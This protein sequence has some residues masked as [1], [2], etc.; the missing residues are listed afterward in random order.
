MLDIHVIRT[1]TERVKAAVARKKFAVDIDE[2][3]SVDEARR[4]LAG[5]ID[6]LRAQRNEV[7]ASIPKL[8]GQAKQDAISQGRE[9]RA[10]IGTLE[11]QQRTTDVRFDDLMMHFLL[12][13]FNQAS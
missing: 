6:A 13:T 11:E 8:D 10:Q 2:L 4:T 9:I 12:P 3:L 7:S 5:Q 1:E